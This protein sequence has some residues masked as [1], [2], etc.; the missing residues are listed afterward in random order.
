MGVKKVSDR[1]GP[2]AP[3]FTHAEE[4]VDARSNRAGCCRL[5]LEA[6][7]IFPSDCIILIVQS[8]DDLGCVLEVFNL[9]VGCEESTPNTEYEVQERP[10]LDC[11]AVT[12]AIG[13]F[14]QPEAELESQLD[15][16]GNMMG[17]IFGGD[18]H[19]GHNGLDIADG[20]GLFLF[21]WRVLNAVGFK[22][23]GETSVQSSVGLGI[24]RIS[25]VGRPSRR[26]VTKITPNT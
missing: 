6:R 23:T 19:R 7:D 8:K 9:G 25:R 22:L 15:Q 11:L 21:E 26:W 18:G 20:D 4:D 3:M 17:F 13:V 5:I 10:E 12:G 16:V 2:W 14:A 24:W 1:G